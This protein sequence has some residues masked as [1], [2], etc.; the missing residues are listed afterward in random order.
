MQYLDPIIVVVVVVVVLRLAPRAR[1]N[2]AS[3]QRPDQVFDTGLAFSR[4]ANSQLW[5]CL[6]EKAYAKAHGSFNA[7]SG[8]EIAEALLDLTGAP[9][10]TV[11]FDTPG[12]SLHR[13]PTVSSSS[14]AAAMLLDQ[15][16]NPQIQDPGPISFRRVIHTVGTYRLQY[17][18][19]TSM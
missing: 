5:V 19:T 12:F 15:R 3:F 1:N 14:S 6:L 11:N 17:R 4:A 10:Y 7:I 18:G 13:R 16:S 2:V 9:T 8:G